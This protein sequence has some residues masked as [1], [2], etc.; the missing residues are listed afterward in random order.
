M[1]LQLPVS[2]ARF[3]T[4]A[5]ASA[6]DTSTYFSA[7]SGDTVRTPA[8]L[9]KPSVTSS[10]GRSFT[11][12]AST[13][14]RFLT[15]FAYSNRV[16]RR[17]GVGVIAVVGQAANVPVVPPVP[18]VVT[19]PA[20]VLPVPVTVVLPLPPAP[21][22]MLPAAPV[23]GGGMSPTVPVQPAASARAR[24]ELILR[25]GRMKDLRRQPCVMFDAV[26]GSACSVPFP[27]FGE[28]ILKGDVGR[29]A[30]HQ[31]SSGRRENQRIKSTRFKSWK[32]RP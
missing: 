21:V 29:H 22:V 32:S 5:L 1:V 19:P 10:A 8:L 4:A 30:T 27:A 25:V 3:C 26:H 23:V 9:L 28:R 31:I 13:F 6:S 12:V 16:S 11:G 14:S 15:V 7:C 20:P 18:V 2:A 24:S 17:S